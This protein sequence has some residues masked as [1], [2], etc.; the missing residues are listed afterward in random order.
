MKRRKDVSLDV[1]LSLPSI[2]FWSILNLVVG[3][4]PA[5]FFFGWV[6]ANMDLSTYAYILQ[7]GPLLTS[8][9]P[10]LTT[11]PLVHA[12]GSLQRV[13]LNVLPWITFGTIHST[14]AQ[15][16]AH[17]MLERIIPPQAIR[18]FYM[19]LSGLSLTTVMLTWQRIGTVV[20]SVP[21][22]YL[23]SSVVL[24]NVVFYSCTVGILYHVSMFGSL[25]S[26]IGLSQLWQTKRQL[27]GRTAGMPKLVRTGMYSIVRHPIYT[28]T[29]IMLV[30]SPV[31]VID[32]A[33]MLA[34]TI[35]YLAVGV[36]Y[37]EKKLVKLF[38][39][40]YVKYQR[41]VARFIPFVF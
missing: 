38:G 8:A 5:M 30:L 25:F 21:G 33:I 12:D 39:P 28:L 24:H 17:D 41:E 14:L 15:K 10:W 3:S 40:P 32:R 9:F 35:L 31:M 6:A 20:Y 34:M 13:L 22:H 26:F 7:P 23:S 27:E 2:I 36:H 19:I 29:L 11:W 18:S 37:E 1:G 4:I 16:P